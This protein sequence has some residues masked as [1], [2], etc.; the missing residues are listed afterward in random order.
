[1]NFHASLHL[2]GVGSPPLIVFCLQKYSTLLHPTLVLWL[3]VLVIRL[4]IFSH[5]RLGVSGLYDILAI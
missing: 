1:M 3:L 4:D 5:C 2:F